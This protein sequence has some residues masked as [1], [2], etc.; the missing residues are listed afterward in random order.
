MGCCFWQASEQTLSGTGRCL[1]PVCIERLALQSYEVLPS[2]WCSRML[3][4]VSR[5]EV[6]V[7]VCQNFGACFMCMVHLH[8]ITMSRL[9]Q[10]AACMP[11]HW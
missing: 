5:S 8:A 2:A 1:W 11:G 6:V 3:V 9:T 7:L 4:Q 10:K